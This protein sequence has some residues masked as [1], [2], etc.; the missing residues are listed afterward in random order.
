MIRLDWQGIRDGAALALAVAV[1]TMV[2]V[3]VVDAAV[4]LHRGSNWVFPFYA[5]VLGG[6][7]AGGRLSARR[8]LDA[9]LLHGAAAALSAYAVIAVVGVLLRLVVDKEAD[10]VALIF[11]GLMAASAGILGG[12]LAG[13]PQS[14]TEEGDHTGTARP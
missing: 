10:P 13:P 11:N 8:R 9:P 6:L 7:V 12:L 14:V 5:V 4:G 1:V 3:E 2:A